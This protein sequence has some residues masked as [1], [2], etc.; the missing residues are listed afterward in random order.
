MIAPQ[1]IYA[2]QYGGKAIENFRLT[3]KQAE[4]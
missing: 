3:I 1:G 2:N 4:I